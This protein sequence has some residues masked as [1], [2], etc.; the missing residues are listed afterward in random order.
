MSLSRRS[1]IATSTAALS[2]SACGKGSVAAKSSIE[3]VGL[4]T[5]TFREMM[6]EDF[7]GTF[8]MIKDVGYDYVELNERN[9]SEKTPEQLK[10]ILDDVGLPCPATHIGYDNLAGNIE[11]LIKTARIL[12]C[13]YMTLPY[14]AD[15]QRSLEDWKRH[16]ALLNEAG[17]KMADQG[18]TLAYHNHQFEFDDLG[19]GTTAMDL[20][21]DSVQPENATFQ[22]DF[23]WANLAKQDIPALLKSHP[24]RFK[25]C[26]VKDMKG[27]ADTAIEN[28]LSYEEIHQTL[29]VDVG[30]GD[31]PFEDYFALNDISGMEYFIAEHDGPTKPYRQSAQNMYDGV[32]ALRF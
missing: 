26:H 32:K 20:L 7:I 9:Y 1:F 6:A 13:Q 22:L 2:L 28:N 21:L 15:D 23:F 3:K 8:Q 29:M 24:G 18:V 16:A 5:Y 31:T 12:G 19:G 10:A 4:Q 27:S 30:Q 17:A 11:G 25:L 14:I